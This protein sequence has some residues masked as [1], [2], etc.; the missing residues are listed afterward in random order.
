MI[1]PLPAPL[2]PATTAP[3]AGPTAAPATPQF[4]TTRPVTI[5]VA[6]MLPILL[7]SVRR[8]PL[9]MDPA[10]HVRVPFVTPM[11]VRPP[12][13]LRS[14]RCRTTSAAFP[15]RLLRRLVLYFAKASSFLTGFTP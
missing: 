9:G 1:A 7:W 12:S 8:H 3:P 4:A 14:R 11:R 6:I 10:R 15:F 13:Q 2:P 5:P